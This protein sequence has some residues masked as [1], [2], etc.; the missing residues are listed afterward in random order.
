MHINYL[1]LLAVLLAVRHLLNN[2]KHT[3]IHVKSDNSTVA[4]YINNMGG[5]HSRGMC[6]LSIRL[7]NLCQAGHTWLS[8]SYIPGANNKEADFL[9]RNS[10]SS[11]NHDYSLN[12]LVFKDL[13]RFLEVTP[14]VDLFASNKTRKLEKYVSKIFDPYAWR[15][16]AFSFHWD[17]CAYMFPPICLISAVVDKFVENNAPGGILITLFWQGLSAIP[18]LVKLLISD[19]VLI[20][21]HCLE[22]IRPTRHTFHLVAWNI[23]TLTVRTRVFQELRQKRCSKAFVPIRLNPMENAGVNSPNGWLN[24]GIILKSL[25]K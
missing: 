20:P 2:G 8:A 24:Q 16:D 21:A 19:P 15:T 14:E 5:T 6:E 18:N 13:M 25:Y 11:D 4:Y 22:G 23:S 7:W 17:F 10:L 9:S 12:S 1:E 3:H